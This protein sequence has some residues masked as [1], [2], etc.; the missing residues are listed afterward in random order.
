[1]QRPKEH[2]RDAIVQAAAELIAEGGYPATSMAAV[3]ARA[4]TATGN[5]YRYF[6]SKEDLFAAVL[7]SELVARVRELTHARITAL[8]A[9]KDIAA[10][11]PDDRY[12]ALAEELVALCVAHRE[13]IIILLARAEGTPFAGFVDDFRA[14]LVAW[15]LDYQREAYPTLRASPAFRF[16]LQEIYRCFLAS[17]AQAFATFRTEKTMREAVAHL[18]AHHQ[19]GLK[20][21]FET[22]A[23]RQS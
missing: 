21:L 15:A 1:M 16:A 7:P 5:V 20:H 13:P 14:D 17:L 18:T 9:R 2:V 3:A 11:P 6:P 10:V 23:R 22:Q 12:H 4:G 8:R 19:G